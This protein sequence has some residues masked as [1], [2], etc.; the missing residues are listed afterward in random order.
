VDEQYLPQAL[1]QTAQKRT[2]VF[3]ALPP[4]PMRW[5]L[6]TF[7]TYFQNA[8]G[9][10][11]P[12]ALHHEELWQWVWALRAG[13]VAP[14]FIA[15]WPRGGGKSVS[16]ELA[17][18]VMG[19]FGLRRYVLY[20]SNTQAQADDHVQN[21]GSMFEKLGVDRA[22]NKYGVSRGWR[23]NRLRT[24]DGFVV[25]AV[26]MDAAIRGVRLDESRPDLLLPDDIDDQ[27]D[28]PATIEKKIA[29]LT[30]KILP[31]GSPAMTVLAV[32]NIPNVDGIFAQLADGRAEFLLDRIV[33]GPHPALR[34][35]PETGWWQREEPLDGPPRLRIVAG[36]PSWAGQGIPECEALLTKIGIQAFL[37]ECQHQTTRL[38][39]TMFQR[40]WFRIVHD[41]P[42]AGRR[43]RF[44]DLAG[45]DAKPGTDPDWTAGALVSEHRGQYTLCDM[46]RIR[47]TPKGVED[48]IAQTAEIDGREVGIWIEQE[49]GSSGKVTVDHYQ[50]DVLKGF[51]VQS[52]RSTGNKAER[53]TPMS[54]AAEAGNFTLLKG[55]WNEDFLL[56]VEGF[57][58]GKHDDQV[59]ATSGAMTALVP[60]QK[61]AG[62]WGRR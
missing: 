62:A 21:V 25:D 45:T 6:D 28:T 32:Q 17:C 44:W 38:R 12:L 30:R 10:P 47:A 58:A 26:G 4:Q 3:R 53:A 19:Y 27:Y 39:G 15:I 42:H 59:D 36:N 22:V 31:S 49:P 54:S 14:S 33:S 16:S 57:P 29:V 5:L 7:P 37:I 1:A 20:V 61:V 56:E 52:M 24:A 50:R 60:L 9:Q 43:V 46:R 11:I 18:T 55:D 48:L 40:G 51:A 35:L 23:I 34:E 2:A 8:Q 41:F 13:V